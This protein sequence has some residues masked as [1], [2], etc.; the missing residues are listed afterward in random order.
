MNDRDRIYAESDLEGR[1]FDFSEEVV[2]VFPDMI[3]RSVPGYRQLLELTSIVARRVVVPGT[4]VYDLGCSLG[5]ATLAARRAIQAEGAEIIAVDN[6]PGMVRRCREILTEDNSRIPV[7][8]IQAD[9]LEQ[10]IRD[11]SLVMMYFT[12]QFI[13]KARRD[14][15]AARIAAGLQPGGM[16]LLAEKLAC[17]DPAEQRWLDTHHHDFKRARGYSDLEIARKRQALENVLVPETRAAHHARL[18]RAG[19]GQVIDWFQCFN[20]A[21]IAAIKQPA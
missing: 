13:P 16:L 3:E 1:P 8:V 15:L 12:L 7:S 9:I 10:E 14:E 20:F 21:C 2:R 5:A 6:A 19:F 17:D 18:E 4:R 11:A